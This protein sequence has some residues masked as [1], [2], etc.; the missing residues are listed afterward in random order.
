MNFFPINT[1]SIQSF[2]QTI[3]F[4]P[5]LSKITAVAL[6]AIAALAT[7]YF[8]FF[9]CSWNKNSAEVGKPD[10]QDGQEKQPVIA[11]DFKQVS[12]SD[13]PTTIVEEKKEV[14]TDQIAREKIASPQ[15]SPRSPIK[16][17]ESDSNESQ[18]KRRADLV[19]K[20]IQCW[21]AGDHFLEILA[22]KNEFQNL[23]TGSNEEEYLDFVA[24]IVEKAKNSD[25]IP[26]LK[27]VGNV[28]ALLSTEQFRD[29][30]KLILRKSK[31]P[32]DLLLDF[33][34]VYIQSDE[35]YDILNKGKMNALLDEALPSLDDG[36]ILLEL[37]ACVRHNN[38][39]DICSKLSL[40]QLD[41]LIKQWKS[42]TATS[43]VNL[44]EV[45]SHRT[46]RKE[47]IDLC[48]ENEI[49]LEGCIHFLSFAEDVSTRAL[50]AEMSGW[51]ILHV[52][53]SKDSEEEKKKKIKTLLPH[54]TKGKDAPHK[55]VAF[56]ANH[57]PAKD[58]YITFSSIQER[59]FSSSETEIFLRTLLQKPEPDVEKIRNAFAVYWAV[60]KDFIYICDDVKVELVI[61]PYIGTRAVLEAVYD[62]I[63]NGDPAKKAEIVQHLKKRH[64]HNHLF[65]EIGVSQETKDQI[66]G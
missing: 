14:K 22:L 5:S 3:H 10:D 19:E 7:C 49:N 11:K 56:L 47:L 25:M 35:A 33:I 41:I 34:K 29:L 16:V 26:V 64:Q 6:F 23:A 66:L 9:H 53:N 38:A 62:A 54:Y 4:T 21:E 39:S 45:F 59:G 52:V 2:N 1:I 60:W 20:A 28:F 65:Y 51:S 44:A 32:W 57:C 63:P 61:L 42:S 37:F 13:S 8:L 18:K 43:N 36:D 58:I 15:P 24:L 46:D 27:N 12:P 40:K 17:Q 30:T 31:N 55:A 50:A 48:I